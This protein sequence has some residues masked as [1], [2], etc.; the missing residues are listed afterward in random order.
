MLQTFQNSKY[1]L[2]LIDSV[3]FQFS[4][5]KNFF[6]FHPNEGRGGKKGLTFVLVLL[7]LNFYL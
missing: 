3:S 6:L 7:F 1:A 2:F 5:K 4:R